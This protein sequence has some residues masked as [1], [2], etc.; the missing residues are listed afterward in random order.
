[1]KLEYHGEP[2]GMKLLPIFI[3]TIT[4]SIPKEDLLD[5]I[6]IGES[7]DVI[8]GHP[9]KGISLIITRN[10][11]SMWEAECPACGR[12]Y[13][14]PVYSLAK[15]MRKTHEQNHYCPHPIC[16]ATEKDGL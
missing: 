6:W 1:M 7:E 11:D 12:A 2:D 5:R 9:A 10:G 14:L 13:S 8:K 16:I 3:L 4:Q 15:A